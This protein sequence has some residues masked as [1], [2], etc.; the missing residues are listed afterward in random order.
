MIRIDVKTIGNLFKIFPSDG[1][2]SAKTGC[3]SFA[4]DSIHSTAAAYHISPRQAR[5]RQQCQALRV[6]RPAVA[7]RDEEGFVE[8]LLLSV[9]RGNN[10]CSQGYGYRVGKTLLF[11][12]VRDL[13]TGSGF[14][15]RST[16]VGQSPTPRLGNHA[17]EEWEETEQIVVIE[18]PE[19]QVARTR[20]VQ[21]YDYATWDYCPGHLPKGQLRVR[22]VPESEADGSGSEAIVP[23]R[24]I[25]CSRQHPVHF[26]C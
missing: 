8:S 3:L 9:D 26:V 7:S 15:D 6:L 25:L 10:P 4:D 13:F 20:E 1:D 14:Q 2:S 12:K 23:K 17:A 22:N 19:E 21:R 11:Q 5:V 24:E 16:Q 18:D